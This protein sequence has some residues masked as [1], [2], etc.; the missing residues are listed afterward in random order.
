MNSPINQAKKPLFS[1]SWR[2]VPEAEAEAEALTLFGF[3]LGLDCGQLLLFE[4][5]RLRIESV[6]GLSNQF[7]RFIS[8]FA[9]K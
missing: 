5:C 9:S 1:V 3:A 2:G 7:C 8:T 4:L 6:G